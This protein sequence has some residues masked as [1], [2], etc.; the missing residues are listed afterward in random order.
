VTNNCCINIKV[1]Y[2]QKLHLLQRS[3]NLTRKGS[4]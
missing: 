2:R 4:T 3:G 1:D